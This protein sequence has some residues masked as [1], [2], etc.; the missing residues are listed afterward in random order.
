MVGKFSPEDRTIEP[1]LWRPFEGSSENYLDY[2]PVFPTYVF[3]SGH[4]LPTPKEDQSLTDANNLS[5]SRSFIIAVGDYVNDGR[6]N[7][8]IQAFYDITQPHRKRTPTPKEYERISLSGACH[9]VTKK[10]L[11]RIRIDTIALGLG[12]QPPPAH[13][14]INSMLTSPRSKYRI[15]TKTDE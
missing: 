1:V 4:C 9:S 5:G 8:S 15:P 12:N 3:A 13:E 10:G 6:Q 7:G 14:P 11:L 2:L